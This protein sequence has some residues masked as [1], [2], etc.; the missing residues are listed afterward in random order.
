MPRRLLLV[1][2]LALASLLPVAARAVAYEAPGRPLP[3]VSAST[4]TTQAL[5][6]TT[7]DAD[8]RDDGTSP[9]PWL[10]GSAVTAAAAVAI[11]GSLLKRRSG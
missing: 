4:S 9:A 3:T 5:P 7:L 1:L 6:G 8:A 11:G 2:T 10:I